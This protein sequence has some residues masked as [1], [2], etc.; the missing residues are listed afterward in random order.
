MLCSPASYFLPMDVYYSL[1]PG[2]VIVLCFV[3]VLRINQQVPLFDCV[4]Q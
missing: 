4:N 2:C 1:E 3:T